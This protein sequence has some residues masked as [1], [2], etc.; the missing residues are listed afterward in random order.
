VAQR[1]HQTRPSPRLTDPPIG[2][3]PFRS[4]RNDADH[5]TRPVPG[6]RRSAAAH[7]QT[8][9]VATQPQAPL[10]ANHR[11]SDHCR[12]VT[13]APLQAEA[14]TARHDLSGDRA[15]RCGRRGAAKAAAR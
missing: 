10:P 8:R 4:Q 3:P 13:A 2:C 14:R 9:P 7:R 6:I 12:F 15:P 5:A 1:I 11:R